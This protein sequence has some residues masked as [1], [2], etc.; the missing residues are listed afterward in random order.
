VDFLA[1]QQIQ[2]IMLQKLPITH[3]KTKYNHL[4][5]EAAPEVN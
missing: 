4:I 5:Q 1:A 2:E 3:H